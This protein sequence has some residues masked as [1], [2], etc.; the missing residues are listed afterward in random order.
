MS[1]NIF[2]KA[3]CP[4]LVAAERQ[5]K[6]I[7]L[8]SN[9]MDD[10]IRDPSDPV[11][12]ELF[13]CH[14]GVAG[15][16]AKFMKNTIEDTLGHILG[17][18]EAIL[19]PQRRDRTMSKRL[20]SDLELFTEG[21]RLVALEPLDSYEDELIQLAEILKDAHMLLDEINRE[22]YVFYFT[23]ALMKMDLTNI[24]ARYLPP[25]LA[26]DDFCLE[27]Y[28]RVAP[29]ALHIYEQVHLEAKAFQEWQYKIQH[30]NSP[31]VS[32]YQPCRLWNKILV[33][34]VIHARDVY[35]SEG[36]PDPLSLESIMRIL[37]DAHTR[38]VN[39]LIPDQFIGIER[40]YEFNDMQLAATL[41]EDLW[42]LEC[43][44]NEYDYRG[45]EYDIEDLKG[46]VS[47]VI[48]KKFSHFKVSI[49]GKMLA[50]WKKDDNDH[51]IQ[52]EH[53]DKDDDD[54]EDL[55]ADIIVGTGVPRVEVMN[56]H[57]IM[58]EKDVAA[59]ED[60]QWDVDVGFVRGQA[61]IGWEEEIRR[62]PHQDGD[63]PPLY[64][65]SFNDIPPRYEDAGDELVQRTAALNI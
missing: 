45:T 28:N 21:I 31:D 20:N 35:G 42:T 27:S 2:D 47:E 53:E 51:D 34:V 32:K 46:I 26:D 60:M 52:I 50:A 16:A 36:F 44:Y 54:D 25:C 11:F 39:V 49:S 8:K 9:T 40:F 19:E 64:D 56:G 14:A 3:P 5:S 41:A 23:K 1:V 7:K 63:E 29:H 13:P 22:I 6:K 55:F 43:R 62:Q 59:F 15:Q 57:L 4:F 18:A 24:L 30:G 37:G 33:D 38:H 61:I 10:A 12:D 58:L 65:V 48:G 17:W